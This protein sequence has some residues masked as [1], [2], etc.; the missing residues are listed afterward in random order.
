MYTY[1]TVGDCGIQRRIVC[2]QLCPGNLANDGPES[3]N[4]SKFSEPIPH[5]STQTP[6]GHLA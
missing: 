3:I 1:E 5:Y 2:G 4:S 6:R